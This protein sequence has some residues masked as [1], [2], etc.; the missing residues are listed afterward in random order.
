MSF[1]VSDNK[2]L[3]LDLLD[4]ST[5][6]GYKREEMK[7]QIEHNEFIDEIITKLIDKQKKI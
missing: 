1:K 4:T 3:A 5:L 2:T 7:I 6:K